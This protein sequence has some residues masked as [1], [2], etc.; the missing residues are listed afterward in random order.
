MT[1]QRFTVS[2]LI[3]DD[4]PEDMVTTQDEVKRFFSEISS[5][6]LNIKTASCTTSMLTLLREEPFHIVLLDHDLGLDPIMQPI[7]GV[8]FIPSIREIQPCTRV[9]VVTTLEST[10]L[11][12]KSMK[13][14]AY[15]FVVKGRGHVEDRKK[16]FLSALKEARFE[17]ELERRNLINDQVDSSDYQFK[18]QAM[19][20]LDN[21]LKS[22]AEVK[23]HVLFLGEPGLGKTHSAKRLSYLTAKYLNQN[24]RV[25]E[26]I[27]INA[28]PKALQASALFGHEKGAF[29]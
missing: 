21:K 15:D 5:S 3:V 19:K 14:G 6:Q 17:L 13:N 26:N 10:R 16:V 23:S 24:D 20:N 28:T 11:S 22:L 29:T 2:V 9:I 25:F 7:S 27:N 18:S 8:D 12:T 1:A 4:S